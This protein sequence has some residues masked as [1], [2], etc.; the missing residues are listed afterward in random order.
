MD[1]ILFIYT[2]CSK[3][4]QNYIYTVNTSKNY[5]AINEKFNFHP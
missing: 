1:K 2:L 4:N 3:S 5:Q